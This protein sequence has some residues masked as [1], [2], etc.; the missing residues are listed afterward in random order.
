M[1]TYMHFAFDASCLIFNPLML[2]LL[3][4]G[5]FGLGLV[6]AG[7]WEGGGPA[8]TPAPGHFSLD[9]EYGT[10]TTVVGVQRRPGLA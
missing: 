9:W 2:D 5:K 8:V 7:S 3:H 4:E 6:V 1:Y 10:D